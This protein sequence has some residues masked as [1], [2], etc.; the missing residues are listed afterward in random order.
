MVLFLPGQNGLATIAVVFSDG[1]LA[2]LV[3]ASAMAAGLN[4]LHFLLRKTA[5]ALDRLTHLLFGVALGLGFLSLATLGLGLAGL[6][7]RWVFMAVLVFPV[8]TGLLIL[9][10]LSVRPPPPLPSDIRC[11]SVGPVRWLW[12]L[13]AVPLGIAVLGAALPPGVLWPGDEARGYDVLEYHLAGPKEHL[14]AGRIRFLPHNVY[15]N[16]PSNVEMLYLLAMVLKS[17]SSATSPSPE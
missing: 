15:T 17:D 11:G 16:M 8:P 4:V 5:A 6:L 9:Q 3:L 13:A 10:K 7:S 2:A 1:L 12:L 14:I